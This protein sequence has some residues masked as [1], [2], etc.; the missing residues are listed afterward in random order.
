MQDERRRVPRIPVRMVAKVMTRQ[1]LTYDCLVRDI[2]TLGARL[3]FP[4]TASLP[5]RFELTLE[6]ARTIRACRVA[7]RTNTLVG[8]EFQGISIGRAA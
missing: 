8:V 7:W 3:E 4:T 6:K 2:S 1:S 5:D